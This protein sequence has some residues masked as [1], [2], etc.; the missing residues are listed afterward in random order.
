[1]QHLSNE[2]ILLIFDNI[3]DIKDKR[4]FIRVCKTYNILTK[5]KMSKYKFII[6]KATNSPYGNSMYYKFW[7]VCNTLIDFRICLNKF[8][9]DQKGNKYFIDKRR[10]DFNWF[11]YS[12]YFLIEETTVNEI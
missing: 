10:E 9:K 5:Q 2:L 3:N 12:N 7:C 11:G 6:S 4:N 8:F 1:M